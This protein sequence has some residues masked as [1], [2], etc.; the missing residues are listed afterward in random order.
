MTSPDKRCGS[1]RWWG[2]EA[3]HMGNHSGDCCRRAPIVRNGGPPVLPGDIQF[4]EPAHATWPRT[5][6]WD[7]CGDW[8]GKEA[9]P[10]PMQ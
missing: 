10:C 2:N 1:C 8:A 3:Q 6:V 4:Y 9:V 5:K 7:W